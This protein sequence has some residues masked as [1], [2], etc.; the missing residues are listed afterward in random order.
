MKVCMYVSRLQG[1]R[2]NY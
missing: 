2:G 1:I